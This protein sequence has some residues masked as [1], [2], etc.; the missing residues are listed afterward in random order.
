VSPRRSVA[1]ALTT[2]EA[3]VAR[4][5][6]VS[7]L[8]GLEGLTIGRLATDL[9]MSKAGVLGHFGTKQALQLSTLEAALGIFRAEVWDPVAEVDA[10]LPRLLALTDRWIG[11]LEDGPFP[12]GCYVTAVSTEFDGRG[13]PVRDAVSAAV[14]TWDA[15]LA[16]EVRTAIDA[17]DLPQETDPAAVVFLLGA[18]AVGTNQAVQL[19]GDRRAPRLARAAIRTALHAG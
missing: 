4:A 8:E 7:S 9:E 1:E 11:Y 19:L 10:G 17:G 3:I 18:I 2:R 6:E 16:R 14:R 15:V 5:V 13:G 12:G